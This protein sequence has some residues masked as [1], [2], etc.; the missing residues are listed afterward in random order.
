MPLDLVFLLLVGAAFL[1]GFI[2]AIA[3][4]GGMITVP[5]LLLGGVDPL[6]ALGTK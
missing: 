1:A 6:T 3:G 4:G 2:D 5:A